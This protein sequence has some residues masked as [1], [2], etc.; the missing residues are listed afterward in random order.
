[1]LIYSSKEETY[2]KI[3]FSFKVGG[4]FLFFSFFLFASKLKFLYPTLPFS[5]T[6]L[7]SAPYYSIHY[8]CNHLKDS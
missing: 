8:R 7:I 5:G 2:L 3:E 1:M 4:F 6:F